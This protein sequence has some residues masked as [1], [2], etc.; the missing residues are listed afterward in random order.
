MLLHTEHPTC[1]T[2]PMVGFP[3]KLTGT[4][5]SIYRHPPRLGEHTRE[6]LLEF[7]YSS[8]EVDALVAQRVATE[9]KPH[10]PS[11]TAAGTGA[12]DAVATTTTTAT[13]DTAA[14]GPST[15]TSQ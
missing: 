13:V 6:I 8:A 10:V 4:P 9:L 14:D 11:A 7:G 1:G 5:Q 12:V 2:L 15:A 3:F